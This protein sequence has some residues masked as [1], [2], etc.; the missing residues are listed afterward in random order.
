M[1]AEDI[2]TVGIMGGGVM[3]GGIGQTLALAGYKAIIRDISDEI[4]EK[5]RGTIIDGRF[6]LKGGV[7]RGKITQEQMDQ[8]LTNLTFTTRVE[9]L[10][11]VDLLI[12]AIPEDL[13]LQ[14]KVFAEL[15]SLVDSRAI[16]AT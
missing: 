6:G 13:E 12:E 2:R 4:L 10:R 15:D 3:G 14:K 8:A 11:Q 16:F 5:T 9:D 1:K 7:E